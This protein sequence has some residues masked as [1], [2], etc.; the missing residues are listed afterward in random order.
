MGVNGWTYKKQFSSKDMKFLQ[1][2]GYHNAGMVIATKDGKKNIAASLDP[3]NKHSMK[4]LHLK[5]HSTA[6]I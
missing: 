6:G 4:T 3:P 1:E 2:T 5:K